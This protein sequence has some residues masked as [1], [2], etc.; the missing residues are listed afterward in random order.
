MHT[1]LSTEGHFSKTI[2]SSEY[3]LKTIGP[4]AGF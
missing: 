2:K 4:V 3:V 1:K